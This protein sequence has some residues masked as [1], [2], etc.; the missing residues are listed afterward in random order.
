[1][2]M[3]WHRKSGKGFSL[4]EVVVSIFVIGVMIVASAALLG[5]VPASRL[6]RNQSIALTV[7]QNQIESLRAAGY[8]ALPASGPF[9]DTELSALSSGAGSIAIAAYDARTKRIDVSVSWEEEAGPQA[10]TLTTLI[11]ETGGL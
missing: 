9:S 11:A 1:M 7:A 2:T 5:G 3:G 8:A 4:I 6:A 10:I